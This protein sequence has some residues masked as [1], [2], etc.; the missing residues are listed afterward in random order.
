M[1]TTQ[2]VFTAVLPIFL[3][4]GL[5]YM[6]RRVGWLNTEADR[7]LMAV[8]VNLLYPCMI[9][10]YILGNDALRNPANIIIP[11]LVGLT[12]IVGGFGLAMI[13]GRKLKIG[14]EK[15]CRTFAFSTGI[16]NFAYFAIPIATLLFDRETTGVLLV[17]NV[18]VEVAMWTLGVGFILSPNDPK[19][20]W[21]RIFSGP[22]IAILVAVP[23]NFLNVDEVIPGF[24]TEAITML[25]SCTIPLGLILIGATFSDLIAT[26]KL[27]N[28]IRIPITA[29]V[30]RLG[31][32][33]VLFLFFALL[34]PFSVE[35]KRILVV[36]AAMPCGVFPV[37]LARHFDGSPDVALKIV[38]GTTVVSFATISLWIGLGMKLLEY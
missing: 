11:P 26:E 28:R 2:L 34:L 7:S 17:F 18:G 36:Q 14:N 12:T 9:F 25:G 20:I 38:I 4:M 33:P 24:A 3:V 29:C 15:E 16:Y 32:L 27:T 19:P 6:A 5:G 21:K 22:V 1:H 13:V 37:L 10:G 35:L 30:L 23:C 31:I 8:V